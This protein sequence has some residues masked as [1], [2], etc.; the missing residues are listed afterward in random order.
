MCSQELDES[1]DEEEPTTMR[2]DVATSGTALPGSPT[3]EHR[4]QLLQQ[5]S[6]HSLTFTTPEQSQ[7]PEQHTQQTNPGII[8][9]KQVPGSHRDILD[10]APPKIQLV[11]TWEADKSLPDISQ[12]SRPHSCRRQ[13]SLK[14]SARVQPHMSPMTSYTSTKPFEYNGTRSVE[15]ARHQLTVKYDAWTTA[16]TNVSVKNTLT[17]SAR[18]MTK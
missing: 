6:T 5:Y 18:L 2:V 4:K 14:E 11:N 1:A 8:Q 10:T 3:A 15:R 7:E 12:S 17:S 13:D 16:K 9:N